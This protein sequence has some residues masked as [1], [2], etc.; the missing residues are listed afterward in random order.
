VN[1]SLHSS[2]ISVSDMDNSSRISKARGCRTNDCNHASLEDGKLFEDE[3]TRIEV[4][5]D[6]PNH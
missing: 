5:N 3:H 1:H 6:L 2:L 4:E